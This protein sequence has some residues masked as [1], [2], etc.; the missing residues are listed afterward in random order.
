MRVRRFDEREVEFDNGFR[1]YVDGKEVFPSV[2]L[3]RIQGSVPTIYEDY[4]DTGKLY[5]KEE[6]VYIEWVL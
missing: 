3:D 6:G 4:G 2:S 1:I 5:F